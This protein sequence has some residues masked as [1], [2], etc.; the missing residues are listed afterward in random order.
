MAKSSIKEDEWLA[1]LGK[2]RFV[3]SGGASMQEIA[4]KWGICGR[5]AALRMKQLKRAGCVV[6]S[7]Y[8]NG[9]SLDGKRT[10]VPLYKIVRGKK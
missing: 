5:S 7:G 9:E 1:E 3:N 4:D 8:R 10:R 6:H 2:V